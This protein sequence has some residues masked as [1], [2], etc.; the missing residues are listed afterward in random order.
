MLKI[1]KEF[2]EFTE[3]HKEM[4]SGTLLLTFTG[5]CDFDL[6]LAVSTIEG[7]KK[8]VKKVP[9]WGVNKEIIYPT[10][11]SVEQCSSWHTA[12]FKQRFFIETSLVFDF[13][14]GLG[15][16]S[17]Y[18]SKVCKELCMFE[19]S[20][21]LYI[22]ALHNFS[23]LS[24]ENINV[25]HIEISTLT[26][27]SLMQKE[28]NSKGSDLR[29][30]AYID[31]SR[32]GKG[33]KRLYSVKDYEPDLLE[34]KDEILK[35]ADELLVK[36]SPME[37]ISLVLKQVEGCERL[38]ILSV[39]NECKE[40]LLL[41]NSNS[42]RKNWDEVPLEAYN[43]KKDGSWEVTRWTIKEEMEREIT[44]IIPQT[45][46]FLYEPN[47][48]IIKGGAFKTIA[49]KFE[50][51]KAEKSS[52]LYFS[53]ELKKDFQGRCFLIEDI[54]DFGKREMRR[55]SEKYPRASVSVR[56]FPISSE[57]LRKRLKI[58]EGEELHIFGTL[59]PQNQKKLIVCRKI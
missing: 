55:V 21:S 12:Q 7:R 50:L 56:N 23:I 13:T 37:D 4:D 40:L 48:S 45:G 11:L 29:I 30:K 31:P 49:Q 44:Y 47:S 9:E 43:L 14:G 34:I 36:I 33:G 3:T 18:I 20:Y 24:A 5:K 28:I 10:Q 41:L 46:M 32:R 42:I 25:Q 51:S 19:K 54:Y 35:Y 8:M 26:I 15:V 22:A 39:N 17:Y 2:T 1:S 58:D 53:N 57:E 16:D 38:F 52:H 6:K 27:G 59:L